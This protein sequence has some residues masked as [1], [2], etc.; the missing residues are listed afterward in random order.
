MRSKDLISFAFEKVTG[1][2]FS[3][4]GK[5]LGA[6]NHLTQINRLNTNL[7][8]F[9][10]QHILD[11]YKPDIVIDVGANIGQYYNFIRY[12]AGYKGEIVSVEPSPEDFNRLKENQANDPK[13][14]LF[15]VACGE[16]NGTAQFNITND[17]K[18]NSMYTQRMK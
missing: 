1:K 5:G 7:E 10:L 12:K 14:R 3:K 11:K 4:G 8:V 17:S 9:S 13:L 15:N 16:E 18:L 6:I 2:T